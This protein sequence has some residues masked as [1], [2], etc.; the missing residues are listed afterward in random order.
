M[1]II[2]G[3]CLSTIGAKSALLGGL[4]YLIPNLYLRFRMFRYSGALAA[5]KIIKGFYQGE[6]LKFA[7][8]LVF[9]ATIFKCCVI[10]PGVFLGSYIGLQM[11]IWLVPLLIEI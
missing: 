10:I 3:R 1:I 6:A 2:A 5:K 11:L 9:F 8:T 4:T 7:L